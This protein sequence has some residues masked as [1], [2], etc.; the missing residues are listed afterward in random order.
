MIRTLLENG[1]EAAINKIAN[2]FLREDR[3]QQEYYEQITRRM[4]GPVL[5]KRGI[6]ERKGDRY[7]LIGELSDLG[8][9]EMV[10]LLA[11]CERRLDDYI[12]KR[13]QAIWQ[14]RRIQQDPVPGSLRY[15]V[16]RRARNR[17]ELCGISSEAKAI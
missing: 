1:G 10:D 17:Y 7:A 3:S 15:Q 8:P 5:T 14:H 12:T 4:P 6:V 11:L 16:L 9:K 13:Q 2:E